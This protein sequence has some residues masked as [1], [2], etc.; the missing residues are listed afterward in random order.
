MQ[1][2]LCGCIRGY[3]SCPEAVRLWGLYTME[4]NNKN[5]K[6]AW[7]YRKKYENHFKENI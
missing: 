7:H 4:Y 2:Q 6:K 5:Y 3:F 1:Y